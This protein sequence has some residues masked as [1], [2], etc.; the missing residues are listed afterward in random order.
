MYQ[1]ITNECLEEFKNKQIIIYGAGNVARV[2]M[3]KLISYDMD[4]SCL[5]VTKRGKNPFFLLGKPVIC[6]NQLNANKKEVAV[7]VATLEKVQPDIINELV[8]IGYENIYVMRDI[9][10]HEWK[11]ESDNIYYLTE[12]TYA[13]RYIDPYLKI[14]GD[15][16]DEYDM[17]EGNREK[18]AKKAYEYLL[19]NELNLARLVVVLGTKCSLCCRDCNNLMPYYKPQE[20]FNKEEILTS[21]NNIL[22][23]TQVILKCELIGGEP[24]LSKNLDDVLRY[25]IQNKTIKSVEIT[26][27]GTIIPNEKQIPLLQ[28]TKVLVRISDYGKLVDKGKIIAF[29]DEH[30]IRYIV[31]GTNKWI[32]A[33]GVES[34]QKTETELK[35]QYNACVASYYCKTLYKGKIFSC[36]RA[37]G[38]FDL[39]YMKEKEYVEAFG[40]FDEKEMKKFLLHDFSL[41]CDYCDMATKHQT[42]VEPAIQLHNDIYE[43][44]KR[45]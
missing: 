37:A 22:Q 32:S 2:V 21:L 13:R 42:Y 14:V 18:Y 35:K 30:K 25:I 11:G 4:I 34:R 33:G 7:V 44:S 43:E 45:I 29:F 20:D 3:G 12:N 23:K 26:T 31:L 9:V 6:L 28:N 15:L 24:F 27:N 38:L 19:G 39:G 10:Y 40:N 8:E 41:A 1:S 5:T 36:A 16:C 17:D